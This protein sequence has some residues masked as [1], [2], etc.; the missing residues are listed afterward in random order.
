LIR[1]AT[2]LQQALPGIAAAVLDGSP[3]LPRA[4]VLTR[5][6]G[7][8]DPHALAEAEPALL[9]TAQLM[10]P[11]GLAAYVRHLIATWVEPVLDADET[12]AANKRA[13]RRSPKTSLLRNAAR[14]PP[15]TWAAPSAAAPAH[16]PC[17]TPTTCADALTA[18]RTACRTWFCSADAITSCGTSA[19][20]SYATC[21]HHGSPALAAHPT[22][23][24]TTT[25]APVTTGDAT[26]VTG[27]PP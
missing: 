8:I 19:R 13:W 7:V 5:L 3:A 14:W 10:D 26:T 2:A 27:S 17:A 21:T 16:P 22:R 6:V 9:A 20:S 23:P 1:I 24:A 15:A 12:T 25:T 18:A 11:T 4:E